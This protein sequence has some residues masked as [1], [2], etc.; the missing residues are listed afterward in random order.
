[1]K[2]TLKIKMVEKKDG[3]IELQMEEND[4]GRIEKWTQTFETF[5][6]AEMERDQIVDEAVLDGFAIFT[7]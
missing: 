3:K 5:G 6:A 1:M 7:K 4:Y 2:K